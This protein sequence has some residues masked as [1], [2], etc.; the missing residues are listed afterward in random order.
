MSDLINHGSNY[1]QESQLHFHADERGV[2]HRCYHQCKH[3]LSPGFLLGWLVASTITFPAEHIQWD[4]VW[5]FYYV[6]AWLDR[7]GHLQ[8]WISYVWLLGWLI[9]IVL[10]IR[11]AVRKK[12]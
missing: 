3:W 11:Y 9:A 12:S 7:T 1:A 5:P 8:M 4:H 6:G 2:L 10:G